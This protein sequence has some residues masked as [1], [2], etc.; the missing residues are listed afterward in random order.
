MNDLTIIIPVHKYDENVKEL[1]SRAL[2][3]VPENVPL[4][5]SA[6]F[7]VTSDLSDWIVNKDTRIVPSESTS[8]C[9]LVNNA[10]KEVTTKWFSILEFDDTYSKIWMNEVDKYIKFKPDVSV[11]MCL[12][13][14]VDDQDK[15]FIGYGNEAVWASSFSN[16]LG[17]VDYDCLQNF[18]DFY[19]TG[20]VFNKEDWDSV[21]GLKESMKLT[22]W[23]EFLLRLTHNNKKVFVIPRVGYTHY[24]NREG[25]LI[26]EYAK[27]MTKMESDGWINIAKQ[28]HFFKNDRNKVYE[29]S[30]EE[31]TN[32]QG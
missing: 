32:G 17:Y 16:E 20:S 6:N 11:F 9:S 25:S 27:T 1:L 15:K 10:V 21:G 8:F 23:Y 18:F 31:K 30:E 12:E 19:M 26:N 7:N 29:P 24:L 13:D 4:I 5:I 28:E 22:F 3:S 14:L 2:N